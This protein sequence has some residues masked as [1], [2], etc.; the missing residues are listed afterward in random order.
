MEDNTMEL[1]VKRLSKRSRIFLDAVNT[2]VEFCFKGCL[3][4]RR[5]IKGDDVC[6]I[7]ML[8][9]IAVDPEQMLIAAKNNIERTQRSFGGLS[10]NGQE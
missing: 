1:S 5:K 9:V 6:I 2:D 3:T 8:Q 7:I 10:S 4:G